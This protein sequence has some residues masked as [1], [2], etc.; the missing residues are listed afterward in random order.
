MKLVVDRVWKRLGARWVLR[1]ISAAFFEGVHVVQGPNGVG[2]TTLLRVIAQNAADRGDIAIDPQAKI[3][4]LAHDTGMYFDLTAL[5]TLQFSARW[6]GQASETRALSPVLE[7]WSLNDF[8]HLRVRNLS[9]GQRQRLALARLDLWG[10]DARVVC[11]DEPTTGLDTENCRLAIDAITR[12]AEGRV[13]LVVS[14][15]ERLFSTGTRWTMV[16]GGAL[17]ACS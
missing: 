3:A 14:H 17:K 4:W 6:L 16:T 9:R 2:K 7:R 13:V 15:D 12:W 10:R 5:E 1:D 11:L 8:S